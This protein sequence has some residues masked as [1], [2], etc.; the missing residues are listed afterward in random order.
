MTPTEIQLLA[1][2]KGP[3]PLTEIS[4]RYLDLSPD[5]AIRRAALNRL[6]FPTFRL[7]ESRKAPV[8]VAIEDLAAHIDAQRRCAK[9]SW[10]HSQA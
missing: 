10:E 2:Y 8:L 4:K 3:I 1:I 9:A 7:S 5:E 6:P